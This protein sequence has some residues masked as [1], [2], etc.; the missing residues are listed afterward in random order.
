VRAAKISALATIRVESET[1]GD[2]RTMFRLRIGEKMVG[3]NLTAMQAHLLVGEILQR[4]VLGR[5]MILRDAVTSAEPEQTR[6]LRAKI[7]EIAAA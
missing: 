5:P 3:E 6:R 4:I 7:E 2:S 1:P